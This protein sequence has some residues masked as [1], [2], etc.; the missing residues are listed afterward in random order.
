MNPD[1][2]DGNQKIIRILSSEVSRWEK[3]TKDALICE[4]IEEKRHFLFRLKVINYKCQQRSQYADTG[5][6]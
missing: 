1:R 2:K 4:L 3:M 6:F 5:D